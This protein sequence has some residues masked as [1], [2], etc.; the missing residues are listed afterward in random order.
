M[1]T[2]L[3]SIARFTVLEA[4]RARLMW[5]TL[6]VVLGVAGVAEFSATLALTDS[7]SYRIGTYAALVRFALV[8]IAAL[9]VATS[10]VREL[11][12]RLLDLTLS[13]PV[14]RAAW[15]LGRLLGFGTAVLLMAVIAGAPLF[16]LAPAAGAA[17]WTASLAGELLLVTAAC[18]TC[19]VTLGHVTLALT[20]V[21]AFYLLSR[22]MG[23]IV[24]MSTGPTVDPGAWSSVFIEHGVATIAL[25]LPALGDF[26]RTGWLLS[27]GP[28]LQDVYGIVL[29]TM[30]YAALLTAAGLFDFYR[31]EY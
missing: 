6:G 26:A 31:R 20:A 1:L 24:L 15:F 13:R 5:M 3:L 28:G 21:A 12:D 9:F 16:L 10:V 25:V 2:P 4:W 14:P 7:A 29:Q 19:V 17:A 30:I 22:A 27:E 23:A 18:L 11:Q 8:F